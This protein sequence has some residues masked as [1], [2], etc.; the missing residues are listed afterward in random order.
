VLV[1]GI[2]EAYGCVC[3]VETIHPIPQKFR[4]GFFA[5]NGIKLGHM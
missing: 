1:I 5:R 3:V 2:Y 4:E